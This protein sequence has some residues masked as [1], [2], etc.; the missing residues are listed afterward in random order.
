MNMGAMMSLWVVRA[1]S[2]GEQ[3]ETALQEGLVCHAWNELP[4]CSAFGTKDELQKVYEQANP[5][6]NERQVI[7]GLNQVWR[8]ARVIQIG[9]LVA[10][11]LRT[12][13]AFAFGRVTGEYEYKKLAPNVMHIRRV[14]WLK[15]VPRS[16]FPK[17]IL[18]SM[19]SGLTLFKVTR[20]DAENRVKK[21]L[22]TSGS[23]AAMKEA[24]AEIE[25]EDDDGDVNLEIAARD[26]ILKFI[27]ANFKSH[28]L[29]RLVDAVLRAQG[30]KTEVSPP[31]PDGGVD[32]L[33]GSGSLGFD[34]PRLCVQVKSGSGTEGQKTFNELMGVVSKFASQQ[35]LLVS[36][37]GFTNPVKADAKK[38]F[39]RIRLWDQGDV[40]DAVLQNYERLDAEIKAELPLKRIWVVVKD[41]VE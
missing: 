30:Y 6:Q 41:E 32:I 16:A 24:E 25:S 33:A 9:D 14:E 19:N 3:Q 39:F 36:W 21:I 35:G 34:P 1:G 11:P 23:V 7:Q 38:D 28:D 15:T 27:Q 18:F 5:N 10:M 17:D 8:F 4:N 22:A 31:G 29:A 20:N 13:S 37:G 40:V 26:E 12:E 2:H